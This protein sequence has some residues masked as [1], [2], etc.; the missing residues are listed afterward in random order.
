MKQQYTMS[1]GTSNVLFVE[2]LAAGANLYREV[3]KKGE[4]RTVHA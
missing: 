4:A 1:Q 3:I 2:A